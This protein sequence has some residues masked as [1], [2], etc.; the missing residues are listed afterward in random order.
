MTYS[1]DY[2]DTKGKKTRTE[3]LDQNIF[4][5][6]SVSDDVLQ[7]YVVAY[8]A[9]QRANIAHTKTRAEVNYSGKKLY[10]QKGTGNARTGDVGSPI[11][12]HGGVAFGPRNTQNFSK[13]MNRKMKKVALRT[14]ITLKAKAGSLL[15]LENAMDIQKT[16]EGF[17]VLAKLGLV[18]HRMLFVAPKENQALYKAVRN[19]PG[20]D[21]VTIN[22]LSPY[23]I[24]RASKL[25]FL[26]DVLMNI[27]DKCK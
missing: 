7:Q 5:E 9:N 24:V 16:K 6:E 21:Y 15:G 4:S 23:D 11:R 22:T 18:G 25:V 13:D 27:V 10:K 8:R 2:F 20:V 3:E 17:T 12:K 1:V 14:A 19:I 26:D